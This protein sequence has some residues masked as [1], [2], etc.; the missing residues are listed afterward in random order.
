MPTSFP[1]TESG[2]KFIIRST[3]Q[4]TTHAAVGGAAKGLSYRYIIVRQTGVTRPINTLHCS[5][6]AHVHAASCINLTSILAQRQSAR[7]RRYLWER[8]PDVKCNEVGILIALMSAAWCRAEPLF[9][10]D[11]VRALL[12][13]YLF[14]QLLHSEGNVDAALH[15]LSLISPIGPQL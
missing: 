4:R 12:P 13:A 6:A 9:A 1:K 3:Y 5:R 10:L 2:D 14:H 15:R 8:A 7:C 11:G